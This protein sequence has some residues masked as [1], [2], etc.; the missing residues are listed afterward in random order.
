MD[1]ATA[2]AIRQRILD[3]NDPVSAAVQLG[4]L[5]ATQPE[6]YQALHGQEIAPGIHIQNPGPDPGRMT[7][8]YLRRTAAAAPDYVAGMQQTP[9]GLFRFTLKSVKK[10]A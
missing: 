3:G 10:G 4:S 6:F 9:E 1:F 2:D 7:E 5:F 8:K